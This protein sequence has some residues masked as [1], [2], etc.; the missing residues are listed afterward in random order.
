MILTK[1][2]S[3]VILVN[4]SI[5]RLTTLHGTTSSWSLWGSLLLRRGGDVR[6]FPVVNV[7]IGVATQKQSYR[8]VHRRWRRRP[9]AACAAGLACTSSTEHG[10][11]ATGSVWSRES[12]SAQRSPVAGAGVP[13]V[14]VCAGQG[15][16][17]LLCAGGSCSVPDGSAV[18]VQTT[19]GGIFVTYV[20][21][22]DHPYGPYHVR[23]Y[24]RAV[25][26]GCSR[27]VWTSMLADGCVCN[28][29][30]ARVADSVFHVLLSLCLRP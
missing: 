11:M 10:R 20:W 17:L 5:L 2:S 14:K 30:A 7:R 16:D 27:R 6:A 29:K 12:R 9:G 4:N 1:R 23:P 22:M 25:V 19:E 18:V 28:C 21:T 13:R 3:Y 15:T 24:A 26:N 8:Q